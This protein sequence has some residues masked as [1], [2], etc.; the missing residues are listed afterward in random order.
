MLDSYA[1]WSDIQSKLIKIFATTNIYPQPDSIREKR[2]FPSNLKNYKSLLETSKSQIIDSPDVSSNEFD[3]K[4]IAISEIR[5]PSNVTGIL[6]PN[7]NKIVVRV[8]VPVM[9]GDT[10]LDQDMSYVE[11]KI[12]SNCIL[13]CLCML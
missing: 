4:N 13:V 5:I 11:W 6:L 10:E 7:T 1:E 12:V 3:L 9:D 2:S 8:L